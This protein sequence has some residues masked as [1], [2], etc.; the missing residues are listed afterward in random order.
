[1]ER[2]TLFI[3]RDDREFC[4]GH[5]DVD[6]R[7]LMTAHILGSSSDGS[8]TTVSSLLLERCTVSKS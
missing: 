3:F 1:M 6:E 5:F 2:Y 7:I 8:M 4:S